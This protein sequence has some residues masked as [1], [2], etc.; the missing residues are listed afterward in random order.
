MW[1]QW[2]GISYLV[3]I[4]SKT[5]YAVFDCILTQKLTVVKTASGSSSWYKKLT[6]DYWRIVTL[7][8]I[9]WQELAIWWNYHNLLFVQLNALCLEPVQKYRRFLCFGFLD[10]GIKPSV[11]GIIA[12]GILKCLYLLLW[13]DVDSN[14]GPFA[15]TLCSSSLKIQE[16]YLII[17]RHW[18]CSASIQYY[19][20]VNVIITTHTYFNWY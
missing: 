12:I 9:V 17:Q 20:E 16:L 1:W 15:C 7:S 5:V 3:V 4:V 8:F 6:A 2:M 18:L 13:R 19:P 11:L 10:W 14:V